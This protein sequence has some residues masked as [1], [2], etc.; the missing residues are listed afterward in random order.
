MSK[1]K[2][3]LAYSGGLD[4]SVILKWLQTHYDYDVIAVCVDVGQDEDLSSVDKK[5]L[6]TGAIKSYVID[7]AEEFLTDYVY[8]TLKAGAMYEGEYLLGTSFARPLM[9]KLLVEIAEKEGAVAIAHG[10]TGKGNDQ[11]RFETAVKALN[12]HLKIIAPWREWEMKSREDCIDFAEKHGIPIPVT[13]KDIYSRD[14]NIWHLSHE[15]GNLEDPWNEHE[16]EIYKMTIRPE[17]APDKATYVVIDFEEGIPVAVDGEKLAPV[18]LLK[19]LNQ[20]A[21]D[22]GIGVIDIVENRLVGMKS[23]GIYET[24]GG[25]LMYEAHKI[26]EKLTLDRMTQS[27][28]RTLAERYSQLVYDGLWFTPLKEAM[29]AF[30][31][32]TQKP[33]TGKVRLKLYKGSCTN[34]G[35]SSPFSM[36]SEEFATFGEDEVYNQ[37]DAEGFIN[38]FA[39]PLTIRAIMKEKRNKK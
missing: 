31:D 8:P 24:P 1:E 13:K 32:V 7:V 9:G 10:C 22:N 34:A 23:R 38:L 20:L 37:K 4:T 15:G 29:D 17:D 18:S 25:T 2:A 28:K 6:E 26:L 12:P 21:G 16:S 5:A 14:Q 11:V 3:V 36:Y 33:V 27:F 19:K 30:V 35:S 39:L